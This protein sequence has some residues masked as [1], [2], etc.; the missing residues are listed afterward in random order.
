[1]D[2]DHSRVSPKPSFL[3]SDLFADLNLPIGDEMISLLAQNQLDC[4]E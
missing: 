3:A 2:D 1:M 4:E